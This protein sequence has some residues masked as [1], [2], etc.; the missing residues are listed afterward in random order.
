[1]LN[2]EESTPFRIAPP[3]LTQLTALSLEDYEKISTV[4]DYAVEHR[5]RIQA[6]QFRLQ[7]TQKALLTAKAARYP[8]I[9]L[10]AGY[11]NSYYYSFVKDYNNQSFFNQLKNNGNEFLGVGINIP[12]FNRLSTR[13]NI[14][15]ANNNIRNQELAVAD[16]QRTLRKEIEQSYCNTLNAIQ[17]YNSASEAL[18]TAQ[19]AFRYQQEK[20]DAGRST[21]FDYNDAKTRMQKAESEQVQAQFEAIFQRK[22]LDFYLDKPLTL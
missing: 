9:S 4:Y 8:S 5:P 22:I 1:A 6:E 21:I 19:E 3:D 10:S 17:Q 13:N 2:L 7:S 14:R 16:A 15:I 18:K 11:S 20:M 12:I